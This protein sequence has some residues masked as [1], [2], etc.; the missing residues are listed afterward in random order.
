MRQR[1]QL[2]A[3]RHPR[4]GYRRIH[5]LDDVPRLA[6][7]DAWLAGHV[8]DGFEYLQDYWWRLLNYHYPEQLLGATTLEDQANVLGAWVVS[9]FKRL[10]ASPPPN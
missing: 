3:R 1:L 6:G 8:T 5:C 7:N 2:L 10:A 4:Y 9:T